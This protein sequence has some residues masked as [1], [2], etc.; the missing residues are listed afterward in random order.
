M[1]LPVGPLINALAVAA[2][3]LLGMA[4]G[5]RLPERVRTIVFQGLG[6]C[7]LVIG[8]QM[9]FVTKSP[10]ILIFSVLLGGVAGELLRLEDRFMALGER[11]KKLLKSGNPRFTEGLVNT[12]VLVCIGAMAIVGSFDEGLRGDRTV[13]FSKAV[14][15]GF[16]ALA[17]ASAYGLGVAFAAVPLLLYQS[18]LVIGAGLLKPWLGPALMNELT[19]TGG[20]LILGIALNL[21]NLTQ[22][23]LSN[24]LPSLLVVITLALIFLPA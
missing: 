12:T 16:A 17:L 18:L 4:L 6:L 9:A 20:V 15:D 19:A 21:L 8:M 1:I 13:V 23:R 22:I 2:G 3:A 5:A 24:L 11:L 7:I 10:V 14:M